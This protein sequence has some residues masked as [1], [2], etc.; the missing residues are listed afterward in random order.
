MEKSLLQ[1]DTRSLTDGNY[2]VCNT[3]ST[4]HMFGRLYVRLPTRVGVDRFFAHAVNLL[5]IEKSPS[6]PDNT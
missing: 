5:Y 1:S 2:F 4:E 3:K 6:Q